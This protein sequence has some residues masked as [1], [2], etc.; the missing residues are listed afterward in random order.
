LVFLVFCAINYN[1]FLLS[2]AGCTLSSVISQLK[3][4]VNTCWAYIFSRRPP[5][6][7]MKSLRIEP[8]RTKNIFKLLK[9][10]ANDLSKK[11]STIKQQF[12]S[13]I[14]ETYPLMFTAPQCV[15]FQH[16]PEKGRVGLSL[17]LIREDHSL[18]TR[19]IIQGFILQSAYNYKLL[20]REILHKTRELQRHPR[21]ATDVFA[22]INYFAS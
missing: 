15:C 10:K 1:T 20:K 4:L 13:M 2:S 16:S 14:N 6:H 11:N 21:S 12:V 19:I 18:T 22:V 8:P 5:D 17:F 3:P 9:F 7:F